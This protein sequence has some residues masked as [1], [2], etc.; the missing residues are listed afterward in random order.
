MT[1]AGLHLIHHL[2]QPHEQ[3]RSQRIKAL[4]G[5]HYIEIEIGHDP[6]KLQH[7]IEQAA[8]LGRDADLAGELR[9]RLQRGND[10]NSLMASGRVPKI[11]RIV[12]GSVMAIRRL[13]WA[14]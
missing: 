12:V 6:G 8:M 14:G 5:L 11:T 7:L 10:G 13:A 3:P 9:I 2:P 4:I 1:R